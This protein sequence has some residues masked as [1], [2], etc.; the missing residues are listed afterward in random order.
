MPRSTQVILISHGVLAAA[1]LVFLAGWF[2]FYNISP[3]GGDGSVFLQAGVA[4]YF[5][6]F[7]VL[8]SVVSPLFKLKALH[9]PA[10][11]RF[12]WSSVS[13][14]LGFNVWATS[15]LFLLQRDGL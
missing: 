13:V 15:M 11:K 7:P 4:I 9:S 14:L 3:L 8:L 5:T 2:Q 1:A 12:F 6:S 10:A